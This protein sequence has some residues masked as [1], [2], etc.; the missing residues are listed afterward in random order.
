MFGDYIGLYA[1]IILFIFTLFLLRNMPTYLQ[2]YIIGNIL[3]NIL[4]IILKLIIKEPRTNGYNLAFISLTLNDI[5]VTTLYILIS[6]VSLLQRYLYK[7][8]SMLQLL[9]GLS[10]GI[11]FGYLIYLIGNKYIIGNIKMKKDENAPI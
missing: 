8:H 6:I 2:F 9:V 11:G 5:F 4:N 10:I 7:N 3:N 1:P